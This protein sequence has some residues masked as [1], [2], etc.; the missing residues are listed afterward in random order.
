MRTASR[1][2]VTLVEL[3]IAMIIAAI[4]GGALMSLLMSMSRFE[5][6]EEGLRSARR[7]GRSAINTL[8]SELRMVDPEWGIESA[9]ATSVTVR[10]PHAMGLVCSSTAVLETL[11]L[12][13]VDSVVL[14]QPGL[15]GFAARGAGGAMSPTTT[16]LTLA[17]PGSVPGD[18]AAAGIQAIAAPVSAPNAGSRAVTLAGVGLPVLS[19]GTPVML[20]RRVRY[21]FGASA[22]A[23]IT[24]R[25]ALWRDFLDDAAGPEELAGPF[26]A[27]AA[28][29]FYDLAA[30]TA[31]AA[32]PPLADV[33][34]L[35]FYLPGESDRTARQRTG[36]EQAD[37]TTSVFFVNRRI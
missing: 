14:A 5:E 17:F 16:S 33:R 31:Q 32:V 12:L 3:L 24:G 20:F 15:S 4:L 11:L 35:E 8:V 13:P 6:R 36:P 23:G 10:V 29:R 30:T 37:M 18:C 19:A 27:G 22:Q 26:D 7:A 1:R 25:T 21:Y 9:S 2:G 34:G 28:F